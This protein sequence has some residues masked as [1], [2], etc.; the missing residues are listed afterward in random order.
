MAG[1]SVTIPSAL[2][3]G[4]AGVQSLSRQAR[5]GI[6]LAFAVAAGVPWVVSNYSTFQLTQAAIYAIALLGLNLLTGYNG[7]ISL[8]HGAFFAIGGY[9]SAIMMHRWGVPFYLTIA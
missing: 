5:L 3:G 1:R 6:A 4:E 2:P 7:Q 8:G 9:T